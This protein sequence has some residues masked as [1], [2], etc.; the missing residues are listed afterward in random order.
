[1]KRLGVHS[2]NTC[3]SNKLRFY[4]DFNHK[5]YLFLI[6]MHNEEAESYSSNRPCD[7]Q[8]WF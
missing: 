8:Y 3:E 1:M 4:A 7:L 2:W 5:S 6:A